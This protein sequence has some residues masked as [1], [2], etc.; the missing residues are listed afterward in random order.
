M[1]PATP[2]THIL[3]FPALPSALRPVSDTSFLDSPAPPVPLPPVSLLAPRRTR[4]T[5]PACPALDA[6]RHQFLAGKGR[7]FSWGKG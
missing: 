6:I 3:F 4:Q 2:H 1:R 5:F 7:D